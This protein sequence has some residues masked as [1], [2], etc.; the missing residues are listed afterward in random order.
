MLIG[1]KH[2][3]FIIVHVG[4][5]LYAY[6]YVH[7]H[8]HITHVHVHAHIHVELVELHMFTLWCDVPAHSF[9]F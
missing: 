5:H 1:D 8:V 4:P 3:C 6:M 2:A 7:M 9:L